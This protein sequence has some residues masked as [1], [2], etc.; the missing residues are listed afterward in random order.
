MDGS[1]KAVK[2]IRRWMVNDRPWSVTVSSW[3]NPR[4][5]RR[6][7]ANKGEELGVG[8]IS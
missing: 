1:R 6:L 3:G 8:Q 5:E 7:T 2:A 4:G